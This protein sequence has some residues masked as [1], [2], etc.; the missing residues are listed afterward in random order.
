VAYAELRDWRNRASRF[1]SPRDLLHLNP[2]AAGETALRY[3][4]GKPPTRSGF[5]V[6]A[7]DPE[8]VRVFVE[9]VRFAGKYYHRAEV[10]GIEN[11]PATGPALLVGN[12]N[13]GLL[14]TD[15]ALTFA[16]V[17]ERHGPD[18]ALYALG[19]DL[20]FH[21]RLGARLAAALGILRAGHAAARCALRAGHMVLVYPGSELD[22]W[23]PWRDRNRI[24]LGGRHG[25]IELALRERVPIV[26]VVSAGVHEQFIVLA[27]GDRLARALHLKRFLRVGIFPIVLAL[28]FGIQPGLFPYV[29]LPAQVTLAFGA[30]ISFAALPAAAADDPAIVERCYREVEAHMQALLDGVSRGRRAFL[31]PRPASRR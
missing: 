2:V 23:R 28:P 15:A 9:L 3:A 4:T 6:E 21:D 7:R 20:I 11:I 12:H 22:S 18:R 13:G 14:P 19:H 17:W 25:F 1:L 26:P 16:A 30:P 29:P 27:R 8:L 10:R 24:E 5:E 31:G